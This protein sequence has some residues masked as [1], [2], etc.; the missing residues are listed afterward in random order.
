MPGTQADDPGHHRDQHQARV[1]RLAWRIALRHRAQAPPAGAQVWSKLKADIVG[2]NE[3]GFAMK[4]PEHLRIPILVFSMQ[5]VLL[6]GC[7]LIF[8]VL[9]PGN[10]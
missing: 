7:A 8:I 1:G 4:V 3:R 6:I 2:S 5:A 10:I 9:R